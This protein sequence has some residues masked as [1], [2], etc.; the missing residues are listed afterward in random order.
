[1]YNKKLNMSG[2]SNSLLN[3]HTKITSKALIGH[4]LL[5]EPIQNDVA[6]AYVRRCHLLNQTTQFA[7]FSNISN[8]CLTK[9]Q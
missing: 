5:N 4:L 6:L 7:I 1:M 9:C 8:D 2:A 3:E